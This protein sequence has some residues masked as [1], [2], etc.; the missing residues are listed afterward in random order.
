MP[1]RASTSL[2][3]MNSM[4]LKFSHLLTCQCPLGLVLHCYTDDEDDEDHDNNLVSMPSRASTSL[5]H[6]IAS[7]VRVDKETACQCPL[8]LVLHCYRKEIFM[9]K[10]V[11]SVCQCPLGLVLHCYILAHISMLVRMMTCVN[12]LSG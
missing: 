9:N 5:L 10:I 11:S 4:I 6:D 3:P 7:E 8:G 1:S 2:L 12:A